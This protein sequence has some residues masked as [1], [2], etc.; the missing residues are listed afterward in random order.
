MTHYINIRASSWIILRTG[1][2]GETGWNTEPLQKA[3]SE[4]GANRIHAEDLGTSKFIGESSFPQFPTIHWLQ[5]INMSHL[6]F[7][8]NSIIPDRWGHKIY[9]MFVC[10]I[11]SEAALDGF[12]KIYSIAEAWYGRCHQKKAARLIQLITFTCLERG[13]DGTVGS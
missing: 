1:T 3:P 12:L 9:K 8:L 5:W 13:T 10:K 4:T 2:V 11:A 7:I 6:F